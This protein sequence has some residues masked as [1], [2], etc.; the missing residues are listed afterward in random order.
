MNPIRD[1]ALL[2]NDYMKCMATMETRERHCPP[3][4]VLALDE[5]MPTERTCS[6]L[7]ATDAHG[8]YGIKTI[9]IDD[10]TGESIERYILNG[11]VID[12][13]G[14]TVYRC[15]LMN[16]LAMELMG[17]K[18][19][20][21][22][23]FVGN[24][25]IN[26]RT[27]KLLAGRKFVIHGS[28]RNPGKN[29]DKFTEYGDTQVDTDGSALKTCDVTVVCTNCIDK[30][31]MITGGDIGNDLIVL[32]C[33]YTL[34]EAFRDSYDLYSDHPEQLEQHYEHEF[35]FDT[36]KHY[37]KSMIHAVDRADGRKRAVYLFG[38]GIA[39]LS[40]AKMIGGIVND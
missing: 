5:K 4:T 21:K 8:N 19:A 24:G 40:L 32:D 16:V 13:D 30:S 20:G 17:L 15:A 35:P 25:K 12:Y 2:K 36:K 6:V 28:K 3:K 34:G 29:L 39:D 7:P 38:V 23:G 33:G 27:A 37:F 11:T 10:R 18:H 1:Y 22:I 26:L 14:M 9:F 31:D